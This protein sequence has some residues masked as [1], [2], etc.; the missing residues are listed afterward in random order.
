MVL[1]EHISCLWNFTFTFY[2]TRVRRRCDLSILQRHQAGPGIGEGS[3]NA[4]P[5]DFG[6]ILPWSLQQAWFRNLENKGEGFVAN[7]TSTTCWSYPNIELVWGLLSIF[8]NNFQQ[9]TLGRLHLL[10][11]ASRQITLSH[12]GDFSFGRKT[13]NRNTQCL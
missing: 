3:N 6:I 12:D 8:S 9:D 1:V 10:A 2:Y 7:S 11:P 5:S 13:K 4:K